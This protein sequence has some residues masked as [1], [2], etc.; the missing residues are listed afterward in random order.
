MQVKV[1]YYLHFR[2]VFGKREEI[3]TVPA[4][5]RVSDLMKTVL[6]S[7]ECELEK[8]GRYQVFK[9]AKSVGSEEELSE[10]DVIALT[11]PLSGG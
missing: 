7:H 11:T 1:R 4:G 10:G 8:L 5:A 6:S 2:E 9:G 3:I